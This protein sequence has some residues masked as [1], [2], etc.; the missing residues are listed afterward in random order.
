[1]SDALN[2][3][4]LFSYYY[5]PLNYQNFHIYGMRADM[6]SPSEEMLFD[7]YYP[8]KKEIWRRLFCSGNILKT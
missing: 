2:C 4:T 8:T 1:M 3:N 5:V 6:Q 7:N